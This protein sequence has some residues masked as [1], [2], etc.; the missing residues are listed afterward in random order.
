MSDGKDFGKVSNDKELTEG[1]T[2]HE[3]QQPSHHHHTGT[4]K[5]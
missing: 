5:T 1:N 2:I 4:T 3:L